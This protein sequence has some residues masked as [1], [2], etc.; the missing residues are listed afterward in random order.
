MHLEGV[1]GVEPHTTLEAVEVVALQAPLLVSLNTGIR[2]TKDYMYIDVHLQSCLVSEARATLK[3][4]VRH[5]PPGAG[6]D[7]QLWNIRAQQL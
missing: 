5:L 6:T 2:D 7:L 1:V 4:V 3:A